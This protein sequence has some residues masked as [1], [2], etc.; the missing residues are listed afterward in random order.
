MRLF[1]LLAGLALLS[2]CVGS[3]PAAEVPPSAEVSPAAIE[4]T[5]AF[6]PILIE[7]AISAGVGTPSVAVVPSL[8]VG[9]PG[10]LN[11]DFEVPANVSV[12]RV[13]L[14]HSA[15]APGGVRFGVISPDDSQF[16]TGTGPL[17]TSAD[18]SV[19]APPAGRWSLYVRPIGPVSSLEYAA[20]ITFE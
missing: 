7:G 13:A 9:G 1:V 17:G 11:Q 5:P 14:S 2:G 10:D 18:L 12:M 16:G 19:E 15:G 3:A 4:A 8:F 6:E 20:E